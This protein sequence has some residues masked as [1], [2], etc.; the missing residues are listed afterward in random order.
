MRNKV[1]EEFGKLWDLNAVWDSL[2]PDEKKYID[3]YTQFKR[4]RKGEVIH[5][6]GDDTTHIV[7]VVQGVVRLTKEGV[8]QRLQIIRLLKPY[9]TFGYRSAIAGDKHSTCAT[10]LEPTVTYRVEREAFLNVIQKNIVFCYKV[11]VAMS[12]DLGI[13]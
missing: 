9:D 11:L 8:G 12:K 10:T 6:E 1:Q 13:S 3:Q 7:M 5:S 4:Y 2:T